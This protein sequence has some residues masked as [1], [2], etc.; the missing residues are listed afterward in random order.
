LEYIKRRLYY[1]QVEFI[2]GMQ[3]LFHIQK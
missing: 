1:D 2:L 3:S